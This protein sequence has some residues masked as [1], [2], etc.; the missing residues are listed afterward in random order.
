MVLALLSQV[1]AGSAQMPRNR[2]GLLQSPV[3]AK[4]WCV[5]S[6]RLLHKSAS[7]SGTA[8][9]PGPI[10]RDELGLAPVAALA[11]PSAL[12]MPISG[13]PGLRGMSI[14][15]ISLQY[16]SALHLAAFHGHAHVV[17][18]LLAASACDVQAPNVQ[19]GPQL[20]LTSVS[21]A[22]YHCWKQGLPAYTVKVCPLGTLASQSST[23]LVLLCLE[24]ICK[25]MQVS[26]AAGLY[27]TACGRP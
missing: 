12:L 6:H 22:E 14:P 26:A 5:G 23:L 11:E 1:E 13:G 3:F 21:R 9:A 19:A 27:G 24:G 16:C 10:L 4:P 2:A 8:H 7:T 15:P 25:S 17:E 20:G 18:A